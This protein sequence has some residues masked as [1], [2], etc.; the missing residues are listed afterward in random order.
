MYS[1]FIVLIFISVI[2]PFHADVNV[3]HHAYI[4]H[5]YIFLFHMLLL[6]V[7]VNDPVAVLNLLKCHLILSDPIILSIK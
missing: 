6:F 1:A 5:L 4:F 3:L 2:H 7:S